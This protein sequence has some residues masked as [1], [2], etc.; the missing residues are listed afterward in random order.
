[1]QVYDVR[2]P[3]ADRAV[4]PGPPERELLRAAGNHALARAYLARKKFENAEAAASWL[5]AAMKKKAREEDE[6][7]GDYVERLLDRTPYANPAQHK[8][9]N[10]DLLKTAYATLKAQAPKQSGPSRKRTV[11]ED[12]MNHILNGDIRE[13]KS[14]TGLHTIHGTNRVCEWYGNAQQL[15]YG[16]YWKDVRSLSDR[17]KSKPKGSTFYPDNWTVQDIKDAIEFASQRKGKPEFEVQAPA[18]SPGLVLF[19]NGD[20]YYPYFD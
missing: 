1:M 20:S 8:T 18:R 17:S 2:R 3:R 10:V 6:T 14:P 5:A 15:E 12:V 9:H 19:F 7:V 13:D 11:G 16:C 4:P